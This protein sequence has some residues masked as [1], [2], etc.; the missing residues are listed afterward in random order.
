QTVKARQI[1][2][3]LGSQAVV[4]GCRFSPLAL[5]SRKLTGQMSLA[6][7]VFGPLTARDNHATFPSRKWFDEWTSIYYGP[8]PAERILAFT[9]PWVNRYDSAGPCGSGSSAVHV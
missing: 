7:R 9:P 5:L 4:H 8:L 3:D 1:I 6:T 2:L